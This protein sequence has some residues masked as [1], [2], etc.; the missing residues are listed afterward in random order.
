MPISEM[1]N[2]PVAVEVA[3]PSVPAA[4]LTAD[5]YLSVGSQYVYRGV[6]LRDSGPVAMVAFTLSHRQGWFI[7]GWAGQVDARDYH[8]Y[9]IVREWQVELSAGYAAQLSTDWQGSF[10][11]A[12]ING[13]DSKLSTSQNYQEWR[14]NFFYRDSFATQFA[15]TDNYR[16]L[17]WSSWNAEIKYQYPLTSLLNSEF[18]LGHSH[19]AGSRDSDYD[20]GW[21]G[22][23]TEWLKTEW[24]LRWIHS[25]TDASYVI[26][27]DRT[28]SRIELTLSWPLP[29]LR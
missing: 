29:L 12:W 27:S 15:Y 19:G 9:S 14:L 2:S 20:Y 1:I 26:D 3:A 28:G 16:Q 5:A 7:D 18:G 25:G 10:S 4:A 13:I 8:D 21:A 24:S 6:A 11:R 17:G 23:R 22:L